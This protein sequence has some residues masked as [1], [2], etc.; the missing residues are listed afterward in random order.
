MSIY[1]YFVTRISP[2]SVYR[3][4]SVCVNTSIKRMRHEI[5]VHRA[6]YISHIDPQHAKQVFLDFFEGVLFE[7]CFLCI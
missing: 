4:V 6:F 1:I 7:C 3:R 2:K 5:Y